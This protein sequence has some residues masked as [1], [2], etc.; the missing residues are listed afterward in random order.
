MNEYSHTNRKA[1]WACYEPIVRLQCYGNDEAFGE[2]YKETGEL[3]IL[4]MSM[5]GDMD[6]VELKQELDRLNQSDDL[7]GSHMLF[8]V[9]KEVYNLR[10]KFSRGYLDPSIYEI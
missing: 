3:K 10:E 8:H 2:Y 1:P 5:V 4:D 6:L 7:V 9:P